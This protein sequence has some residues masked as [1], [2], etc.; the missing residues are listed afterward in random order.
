MGKCVAAVEDKG[1][2]ASPLLKL[3]ACKLLD[4]MTW[5]QRL[6]GRRGLKGDGGIFGLDAKKLDKVFPKLTPGKLAG[7]IFEAVFDDAFEVGDVDELDTVAADACEVL[8]VDPA[9]VAAEVTAQR[10]VKAAPAAKAKKVDAK[11][12]KKKAGGK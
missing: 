12:A 7:L 3:M 5:E 10:A 2:L 6:S 1:H 11:P 8:G 9:K 4:A